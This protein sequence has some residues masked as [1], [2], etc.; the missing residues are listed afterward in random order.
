MSRLESNARSKGS[1]LV[2]AVPCRAERFSVRP[3]ETFSSESSKSRSRLDEA[4]DIM[5]LFSKV[6]K[7][8]MSRDEE[9]SV[10]DSK[11]GNWNEDTTFHDG[12]H[13][14]F[15]AKRIRILARSRSSRPLIKYLFSDV[16]LPA[17]VYLF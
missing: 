2:Q 6:W 12:F 5:G 8:K 7:R 3:N 16:A 13:S 1:N 15:N 14:D 4:L 9:S 10:Q 17:L 11:D